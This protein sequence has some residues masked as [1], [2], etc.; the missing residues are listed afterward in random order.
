MSFIDANGQ[1]LASALVTSVNT[2]VTPPTFTYDYWNYSF[3]NDLGQLISSVAPAG[4][5]TATTSYPNFVTTYSYDHMGRLIESSGVDD[6]TSKYTYS[7]DGKIRFSQNQE[8]RNANPQRFSYTNYDYLGRLIE[9]GEYTTIA[10]TPA[11]YV[12]ETHN[13]TSPAVNSVLTIA[14]NTEYTGITRMADPLNRCSDYALIYYD[15]PASDFVSDTHHTVQK[16]LTGQVSKTENAEAKTWYSYDE[17]GQLIWTKQF[18]TGIGYKTIDYIYDY[19]GNVTDVIYQKGQTDA[20][21]HHYGYDNDQRL[22]DVKTS[23]DGSNKTLQA[24]YEYYLHGPLKRIELAGN[25]QGID[26]V[27]TINGA[28]KSI[29]H[30][31]PVNDPGQDGSGGVNA[32]FAKDIFGQTFHYFDND[33]AGASYNPSS[34]SMPGQNFYGGNLKGVSYNSP[35]DPLKK[36]AYS[37]QYDAVNQLINS[38]WGDVSGTTVTLNEKQREQI[39]SYD[40]NGNIQSLQRKGNDAQVT[41]NYA[42]VYEANTNKLDKV[43]HNGAEMIDYTYNAIGQMVSQKEN[44]QRWTISYTAYGLVKEIKDSANNKIQTYHYDDRGDMYKKVIYK[45]GVAETAVFYVH[46]ASGSLMAMYQQPLPS[47]TIQL[48]E[49]PIYGSGRIGTYKPPI[50]TYCKGCHRYAGDH[51]SYSHNGK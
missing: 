13:I 25:K 9:S 16:Y 43:N 3:Y 14:E 1:S 30:A 17:F 5:N 18:I 49:V 12:F 31:D 48:I 45:N 32:T 2:S 27:Y 34:A 8:Q 44:G 4:V 20:F 35:V 46:D 23:K 7:N 33:Y 22:V 37:F 51:Y 26:Y 36:H 39:P 6:G 38:Q 41:A 50:S 29:N 19:L 21:Y 47:G 15:T 40:K 10:G 42:Y 11:P 24:T 28:L